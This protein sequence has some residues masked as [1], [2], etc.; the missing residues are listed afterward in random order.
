MVSN[1]IRNNAAALGTLMHQVSNE[2]A[3]LIRIVRSNLAAAA[4]TAEE[5][6]RSFVVP[7]IATQAATEEAEV[8]ELAEDNEFKEAM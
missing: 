8:A 3:A 7:Q 2:Q 6:E 1:E 5:M 4:D